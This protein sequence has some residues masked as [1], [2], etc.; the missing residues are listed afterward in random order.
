MQSTPATAPGSAPIKPPPPPRRKRPPHDPFVKRKRSE[1]AQTQPTITSI[2]QPALHAT[3]NAV[4]PQTQ[5]H[6]QAQQ[7]QP[8]E[9]FEDIPIYT[10]G[11][12]LLE[13]TRHHIMRLFPSINVDKA[14][15]PRDPS[16]FTRP[17]RLH[18]RDP[19]K[20]PA[21]NQGEGSGVETDEKKPDLAEDKAKEEAN[22]ANLARAAERDANKA[23]IAPTAKSEAANQRKKQ[24]KQKKT[25]M[26]YQFTDS[27]TKVKNQRIRYEE[28][29]PWH[30]EDFD[31]KNLWAGTYESA[32]SEHHVML[33]EEPV[34]KAYRMIPLEKWYKFL[35]KSHFKPKSYDEAE[36]I[37][38][39]QQ[40]SGVPDLVSRA[41]AQLQERKKDG[42]A[43]TG[44]LFTRQGERGERPIKGG[45][46]GD[47]ER[48]EQNEDADVLDY[49][50]DEAFADD[51]EAQLFGGDE[52]EIKEA[53]QK[54][55]RERGDANIFKDIKEEKDFDEEEEDKKRE[56]EKDKEKK[57]TVAKALKKRERDWRYEDDSDE[58]S[59]SSEASPSK[60]AYVF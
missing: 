14:V 20:D 38:K 8:Q 22:A 29:M 3:H 15:D 60:N 5:H 39:K 42:P 49:D 7:Q 4:Q 48:P 35:P 33:I 23:Q 27:A 52:E 53:E 46:G 11:K 32:L 1:V 51:E 45:D 41:E 36:R 26:V 6:Q 21:P 59:D 13:G 12:A 31:N 54:V 19:R 9:A 57:K 44:K 58:S 43:R 28:S 34:S 30:L 50:Y 10:T 17:I 18:R 56:E 25:D 55:K 37:M 40:Q 2:Q 16:Q 47:G 24:R